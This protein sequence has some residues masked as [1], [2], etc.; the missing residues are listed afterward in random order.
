MV[1]KLRAELEEK[2]QM[3]ERTKEQLGLRTAE[4]RSRLRTKQV[5]A[6]TAETHLDKLTHNLSS[7]KSEVAVLKRELASLREERRL[8]AD[9]TTGLKSGTEQLRQECGE[10][11]VKL[12]VWK[13]SSEQLRLGIRTLVSRLDGATADCTFLANTCKALAPSLASPG[14]G[15]A[16]AEQE[17]FFSPMRVPDSAGDITSLREAN[18]KLTEEISKLKTDTAARLSSAQQREHEWAELCKEWEQREHGRESQ[19]QKNLRTILLD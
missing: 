8:I 17:A 6:A 5:D 13:Q 1:N 16:V 14:G 12:R 10:R 18:R 19:W 4:H 3:L 15:P 7:T 2:H 9:T 11:E